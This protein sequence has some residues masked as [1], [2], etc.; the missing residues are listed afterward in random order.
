VAGAGV[1]PESGAEEGGTVDCTSAM[2][3]AEIDSALPRKTARK[4][5]ALPK[6]GNR[7]ID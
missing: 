4:E 5:G 3:E 1:L 2:P 7:M 6:H